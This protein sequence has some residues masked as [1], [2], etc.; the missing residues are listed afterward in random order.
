M[1]KYFYLFSFLIIFT[2]PGYTQT[3]DGWVEV[4][5]AAYNSD[6]W[7]ATFISND[8]GFAVGNGGAFLKTTNGGLT[9][10]AYN[11][12][13]DYFFVKVV[14]TSSTTGYLI[15][16]KYQ[17]LKGRVLKTTDGGMTWIEVLA[18]ATANCNFLN[19]A[20]FSDDEHGCL[21]G[22]NYNFVT[23]NGGVTWT[24]VYTGANTVRGMYFKNNTD[25]FY[26][27]GYY[28]YRT[29]DGG[30]NW[31]QGT[32]IVQMPKDYCFVDNNTGYLLTALGDMIYKTND[33]GTTWN[34]TASTGL[35]NQSL[36]GIEF[37]NA[38]TGYV[39]SNDAGSV[40]TSGKIARTTDGGATWNIVFSDITYTHRCLVKKPDND[41]FC[42][43][44][45]G[46]ILKSTNGTIW[47]TVQR[48]ILF[49]RLYD[50]CF[51]NDSTAIAVGGSGIIAKTTNHCA[52]WTLLNSG[53]TKKLLNITSAGPS[54][55][56]IT[57][58][59]SLLLKST[60]GGLTWFSSNSGYNTAFRVG[61]PIAFLNGTTGLACGT[62]IHKT[63]NAGA[64]WS[65]VQASP[66]ISEL[67]AGDDDT[68]YAA[69]WG[70]YT[71]LYRSI[72]AG[73]SWS[74]IYEYSTESIRSLDFLS[75]KRGMMTIRNFVKTTVDAGNTWS[76]LT[77]PNSEVT[78]LFSDIE[79]KSSLDATVVGY[80]GKIYNSEDGGTTWTEIQSN[81]HRRIFKLTYGPD[82]TGYILAED[83]QIL[84]QAID[85]TYELTFT[86]T[87]TTGNNVPDAV[88]TLNGYTY[89]A[90]VYQMDGL[91]PGV[92]N[93]SIDC[94]GY[95]TQS[96]LTNVNND[97]EEMI[98]LGNCYD[99]LIVVENIFNEPVEGATVTLAGH[100]QTTNAVGLASFNIS[101]GISLSLNISATGYLPHS[102]TIGIL[103]DT[104]ITVLLIADLD[105]PIALEATDTSYYQFMANWVL[106]AEADSCLLYVS[107][108]DF[109]TF[110]AGYNGRSFAGSNAIVNGLDEGTSYKYKLK[111]KNE[112]G[113]SEFSEEINVTTLI[114]SSD[115]PA[116]SQLK[117]YPN[118][119]AEKL[120]I[121]M[122]YSG[123]INIEIF[124][125]KGH[126]VYEQQISGYNSTSV[127]INV[128]K[129]PPGIYV[130]RLAYG[131]EYAR[132]SFIRR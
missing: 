101:E 88:I 111:A 120:F 15:G 132:A 104:T 95:C 53:T 86:I 107:D 84:R 43:G 45:G 51:L 35:M 14:F 48:G 115:K 38:N 79:M 37:T 49:D 121:L 126:A 27:T 130:I 122:N 3:D 112:Y 17:N 52:S 97:T 59:D 91:L 31:T 123:E 127:F 54:T 20:S 78:N 93:W 25:G 119:V 118:P 76:T 71:K 100:T 26:S 36:C 116:V 5:N 117:I 131:D 106:P 92:Y 67:E 105:S 99:A 9:W 69:E 129:L 68:L 63:T 1:K 32:Y 57:G 2:L 103:S 96:G 98:I 28:V 21:G 75:A 13:L 18:V 58:V 90:G 39:C 56:Y 110:I 109:A 66:G 89:P 34:S 46:S 113:L 44:R 60:D 87:N 55:L 64:S 108:D 70:Y 8:V 50:I 61:A 72:D 16:N 114:L 24:E 42:L 12:G 62:N 30:L 6:L 73:N 29:T 10:T 65:V 4:G 19:T 125:M 23:T 41:L 22:E 124:D 74:V 85:D 40:S 128:E 81:T 77:I 7:S 94:A 102:S 11:T 83:A 80:Y 33:G 82:G 47:S